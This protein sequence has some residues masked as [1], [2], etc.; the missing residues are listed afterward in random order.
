MNN[1]LVLE[2]KFKH[3]NILR[4]ESQTSIV[5]VQASVNYIPVEDFREIF[6]YVG[7]SIKKEPI[8]KLIFDKTKL[9]VF[10]QPS[11]EWYFLEW[12]EK[13]YDLGLRTHRKILPNDEVF[14]HS[15]K[16]GR[17]KI[18]QNFPN[19]KFNLMDIQYA[20]NIDEAIEN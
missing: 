18:K 9:T 8:R 5:V 19:G 15:V 1:K 12:K 11:M 7:E 3:A 13:M 10:H 6:N 4:V 2:K 14:K 16:I 20:Q 17:E